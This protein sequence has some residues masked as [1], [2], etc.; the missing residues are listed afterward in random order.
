MVD[1]DCMTVL[2]RMLDSDHAI[3]RKVLGDLIHSQSRMS[4]SFSGS[5][6]EPNVWSC[7]HFPIAKLFHPH[8]DRRLRGTESFEEVEEFS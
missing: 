5:Y 3:R 4:E 1:L 6:W 2:D 7:D 8:G